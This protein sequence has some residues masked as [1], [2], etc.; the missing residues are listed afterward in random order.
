MQKSNHLRVTHVCLP[1][2][3]TA[4]V[5]ECLNALTHV[6]VCCQ[7]TVLWLRTSLN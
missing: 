1:Y 4:D 5:T 7:I 2:T 3:C 6:K